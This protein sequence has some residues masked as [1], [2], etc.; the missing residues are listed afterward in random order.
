MSWWEAAILGLV[1]G[2]TE[3]L[4]ISSSGHLVLG[5]HVLGI[6]NEPGVGILFEVLVHFGTAMSIVVVYRRELIELIAGFFSAVIRPKQYAISWRE[7]E[8]FRVSGF[9]LLTM[10]PTGIMYVFF[11]DR[12]EALFS[13]PW[14]TSMMLIVTG[15]LLLLTQLRKNPDGQLGPMKS[16]LIGLAQ[17]FAMIPGI[18]RSGSTICTAIYLNVEPR[19]AADFSFLMLLPIVFGATILKT[20]EFLAASASGA[21]SNAVGP[22]VLGTI[23]SFVTGILAIKIVL[24]FVRKGRLYYFAFYCFVVGGIG[25]IL[26]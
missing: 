26:L 5:K 9:I 19:R 6:E 20:G 14:T 10:I 13:D 2:F 21:F 24:G 18:S 11:K 1:Q 4:P 15:I 22:L 7:D 16:L 17:A 25:L 12:L 8:N 3:F 23:V